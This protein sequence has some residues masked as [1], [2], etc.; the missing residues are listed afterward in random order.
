MLTKTTHDIFWHYYLIPQYY[1]IGPALILPIVQ[2]ATAIDSRVGCILDRAVVYFEDGHKT[3][4]GPRW[5]KGGAQHSFGGHAAEKFDIAAGVEITKVEIGG[6]G[7]LNGLR[8]HMSDGTAGG[9]LYADSP[10]V[11]LGTSLSV[12]FR[13][14]S[15]FLVF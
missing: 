2:R 7:S 6:E 11:C 4:C 5:R 8:F 10:K 3:P 1:G 13:S 9:Y 14:P 12:A 15:C